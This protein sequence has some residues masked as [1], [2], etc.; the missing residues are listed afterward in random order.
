VK[1]TKGTNMRSFSRTH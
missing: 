1:G